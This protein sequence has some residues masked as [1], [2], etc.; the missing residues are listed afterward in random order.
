MV[1]SINQSINH[2]LAGAMFRLT[3]TYATFN[4]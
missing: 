1:Q 2:Q 4:G 3:Q